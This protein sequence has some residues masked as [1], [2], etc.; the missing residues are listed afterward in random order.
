MSDEKEALRWKKFPVLNDGFV[1]LV[2]WM[3]DDSSVVQAA[4]VSYGAGTKKLSDDETLIRFLMR[5]QHGTPLEMT[6]IKLL[7]R[8]P[9]DANRQL[10]RHRIFSMNEYSTR[11]SVAIDSQQETDPNEWRLQSATN[12]QGSAS[13]VVEWPKDEEWQSPDYLAQNLNFDTPGDYLKFRETATQEF[14]REVYEERLKFGVARE[15]ARKDLPLSTY[16]E[17]YW[18]CNLRGFFNFLSLRMDS[19]AQLE[20]RSYANII[21][22]EIIAKLY[23]ICWQAFKDYDPLQDGLLLSAL[24]IKVIKA[25][26]D[27]GYSSLAAFYELAERECGWPAP[28]ARC[29]ERDESIIKL[30]RLGLAL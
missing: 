15:Q 9:M 10:V 19:H 2:D 6:A 11:Y 24:D 23:P 22:N 30:N 7:I 26:G 27:Y 4:R 25:M 20:I 14:A 13:N 18:Q 29:R 21:G 5:H 8:L 16:T 1:T 28:P 17:L 12:K 3:G